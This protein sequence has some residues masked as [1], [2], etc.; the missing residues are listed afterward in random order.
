M[1]ASS[2][3]APFPAQVTEHG[4]PIRNIWYML[5]YAWNEPPSTPY[6]K[7]VDSE[8]SPTLDALLASV[9]ART[10]QQR[11]RIGLGCGY[12]AEQQMLRGIRGRIDL[13]G[14]IKRFAFERRQALCKFEEYTINA[15][16]NQIIRSTLR[17]LS[18]VGDFG[19]D[20]VLGG[21]L[22]HRLS[23]LTQALDSVDLI[24]LTPDIVRRQLQQRHD[25]DYRIML[26]ICDFLLSRR[27]PTEWDGYAFRSH[28]DRDRFLLHRVYQQFVT[29]FYRYHLS[30]WSVL[31]E[32]TLRWLGDHDNPHLPIMHPDLTL[33]CNL[34]NGRMIVLDTKFTAKSL[35]QNQWGKEMYDSSHLYQMYAYL[36][37]QE[38]RS[39]LHRQAS[40]ILLYPAVRE[41][42]QEIIPLPNHSIRIECV[43]LAA[44]WQDVEQRLMDVVMHN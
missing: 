11:L 17:C 31:A 30:D 10:L 43:D 18:Q 13:T 20:G 38:H 1:N 32:Q 7:M 36:R 12:C 23:W 39:E 26:A 2:E 41:E 37:T 21:K 25:H 22:H 29:A 34:D 6:W 35:L 9:L 24:N 19:P 5:M 27:M 44:R 16:K 15:L 8:E 14:S 28:L 33:T 3:V 40:G 4:I 42:L